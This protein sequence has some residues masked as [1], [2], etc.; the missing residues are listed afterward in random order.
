MRWRDL[1][2]TWT[3]INHHLTKIIDPNTILTSPIAS[4]ITEIF[5]FAFL[6][7]LHQ[8]GPLARLLVRSHSLTPTDTSEKIPAC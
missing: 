7:F 3:N 8:V 5:V 6:L 4:F 1:R 2:M